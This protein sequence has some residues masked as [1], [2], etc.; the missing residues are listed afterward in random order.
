MPQDTGDLL[1]RAAL[2]ERPTDE[3]PQREGLR[4]LVNK[5]GEA[6]QPD[7]SPQ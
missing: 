3:A 2:I 1:E 5:E 7:L 6:Y 4:V